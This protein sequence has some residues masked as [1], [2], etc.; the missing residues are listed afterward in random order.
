MRIIPAQLNVAEIQWSILVDECHRQKGPQ[1]I[2]MK[3]LHSYRHSSRWMYSGTLLNTELDRD[4]GNY[5]QAIEQ[6]NWSQ[7]KTTMGDQETV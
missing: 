1:T 3:I 6:R 5:L 7:H 2:H 4:L